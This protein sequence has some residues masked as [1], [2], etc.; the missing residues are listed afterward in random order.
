VG[1]EPEFFAHHKQIFTFMTFSP[2]RG[3]N[4]IE[5]GNVSP[6]NKK[7]PRLWWIFDWQ[8][9]GRQTRSLMAPHHQPRSNRNWGA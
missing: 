4:F 6:N 7:P 5:P 3:S 1:F 9:L 8:C 2:G